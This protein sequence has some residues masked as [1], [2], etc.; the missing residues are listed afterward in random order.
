MGFI[1]PTASRQYS[2]ERYFYIEVKQISIKEILPKAPTE[3]LLAT[4]RTKT[5][6]IC[7]HIY[8]KISFVL[9]KCGQMV[10]KRGKEI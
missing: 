3:R 2:S 10:V 5:L 1:N 9:E 6:Y 4:I 7:T 8:I